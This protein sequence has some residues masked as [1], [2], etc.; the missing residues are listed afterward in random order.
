MTYKEEKQNF[1]N[2]ISFS[3]GL[4][5][6]RN[7]EDFDMDFLTASSNQIVNLAPSQEASV[8]MVKTT[9]PACPLHTG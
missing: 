3:D 1:Q 6:I 7:S 8:H 2:A 9:N 5:E 4:N